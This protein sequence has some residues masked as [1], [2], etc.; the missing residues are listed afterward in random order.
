MGSEASPLY[1]ICADSRIP[2]SSRYRDRFSA[3]EIIR[4]YGFEKPSTS[5]QVG[6]FGCD[7]GYEIIKLF[8]PHAERDVYGSVTCWLMDDS[9][10]PEG[11]VT[12]IFTGARHGVSSTAITCAAT[13]LI[14]GSAAKIAQ[15]NVWNNGKLSRASPPGDVCALGDP[16]TGLVLGSNVYGGTGLSA[17][18]WT[19]YYAYLYSQFADVIDTSP[20]EILGRLQCYRD[21]NGNNGSLQAQAIIGYGS[22]RSYTH[23]PLCAVIPTAPPLPPPVP[24][25]KIIVE[26]LDEKPG[27]IRYRMSVDF[28]TS[29]EIR[30]ELQCGLQISGPVVEHVF[31]AGDWNV[32]VM[33]QNIMGQG[34]DSIVV[35]VPSILLPI[36][37]FTASTRNTPRPAIISFV[38][39]T[40]NIDRCVWNFGDGKQAEGAS[41][42]HIYA[43]HGY[44]TIT[45]MVE[46][47]YGRDVLIKKDYIYVRI[48]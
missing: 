24:R 14:S 13:Q 26:K 11:I 30:W 42:K 38:C 31:P 39:T 41:V 23:K 46:N 21:I 33:V 20:R 16:Q 29:C 4:L 27:R 19:A 25:P 10:P 1:I 22:I 35:H 18:I 15:E 34:Y 45:L 9:S 40:A 2:K 47:K 5:T 43:N 3:D 8:I 32:Q 17:I 48:R 36:A 12:P 7:I 37:T 28:D 44:Y 6:Y